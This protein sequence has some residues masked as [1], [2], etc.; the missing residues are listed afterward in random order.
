MISVN[1][2]N[3]FS[4][5]SSIIVMSL[6]I[7]VMSIFMFKIYKYYSTDWW[8]PI[9]KVAR[10]T[11]NDRMVEKHSI[12]GFPWTL[13]I[14]PLLEGLISFAFCKMALRNNVIFSIVLPFVICVLLNMVVIFAMIDYYNGYG[15]TFSRIT[16]TFGRMW[17]SQDNG[18]T[19]N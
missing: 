12:N 4:F 13:F 18:I 16:A 1:M 9:A 6:F 15:D 17:Y 8:E 10:K 5:W 14:Y 19:V 7:V 2:N 11:Y 3:K